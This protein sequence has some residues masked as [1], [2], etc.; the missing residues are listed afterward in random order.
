MGILSDHD[1]EGQVELI[2]RLLDA[3]SRREIW[4]S[5]QCTPYTFAMLGIPVTTSDA[6]LWLRCQ[7]DQIALV[8]A[9][10]NRKGSDSLEATLQKFNLPD[11]LPVFTLANAQRMAASAAFGFHNALHPSAPPSNMNNKYRHARFLAQGRK[12]SSICC[13]DAIYFPIIALLN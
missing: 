8:T 5:L 11:C 3:P 1:I 6:D 4:R 7:R 13:S 12:D 2:L 9:N 10:R